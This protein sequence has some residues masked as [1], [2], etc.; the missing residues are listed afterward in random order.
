LGDL[1]PSVENPLEGRRILD[2]RRF[3]GYDEGVVIPLYYAT[4]LSLPGLAVSVALK[5]GLFNIG[6]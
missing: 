3:F 5:A 6:W 1:S 4:T 2:I